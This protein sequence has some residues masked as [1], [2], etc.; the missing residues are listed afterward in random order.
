MR[1]VF[2]LL[3]AELKKLGATI[4][5]AS[6]SRI[7]IDTGKIDLASAHDYCDCML[8]TLQKRYCFLW[9]FSQALHSK[10]KDEHKTSLWEHFFSFS[11]SAFNK[12]N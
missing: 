7:I 8:N 5:C 11:Y 12:K 9:E 4:I 3:V 2:A 10:N 1:K 6:F